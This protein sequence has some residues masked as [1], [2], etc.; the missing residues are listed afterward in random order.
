MYRDL[1]GACAP[2]R[3]RVLTMHMD[4]D[5]GCSGSVMSETGRKV[6]EYFLRQICLGKCK[7]KINRGGF[8][9]MDE[10]YDEEDAQGE[11]V[12]YRSISLP[13]V[14]SPLLFPPWA[15]FLALHLSTRPSGAHFL[16]NV[17]MA[18]TG[19]MFPGNEAAGT[20]VQ[21]DLLL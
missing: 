19:F 7:C 17:Q 20:S 12:D 16:F 2:V 18:D 10:R 9:M 5:M 6:H 4:H 3:A 21:C 8:K 14:D 13:V 11:P 1:S 15:H